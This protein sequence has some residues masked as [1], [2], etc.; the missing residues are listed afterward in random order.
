MIIKETYK[1]IRDRMRKNCFISVLL[2]IILIQNN[3]AL[4]DYS[5]FRCTLTKVPE[6]NSLLQKSRLPFGVLIHP[7]KD[8]NVNINEFSFGTY[9]SR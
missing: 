5:I 3:T 7:F 1:Y 8:L 9:Q 6:S 4:Y 2:E